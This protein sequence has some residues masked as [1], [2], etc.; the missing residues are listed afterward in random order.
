MLKYACI[1]LLFLDKTEIISF[2]FVT[3]D[4]MYTCINYESLF[5]VEIFVKL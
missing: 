4:Q 1:G 3:D 2:S 5:S